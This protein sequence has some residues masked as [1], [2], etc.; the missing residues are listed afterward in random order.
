MSSRR[1]TRTI[2][3]SQTGQWCVGMI[4]V[5]SLC[6]ASTAAMR[7]QDT[8]LTTRLKAA[9]VSKLPQFVEWPAAAL[10]RRPAI[11]VCVAPPDPF[12]AEL[13]TLL[14]GSTV[15]GRPLVARQIATDD[16]L[17]TCQ[18][19]YFP[20]RPGGGHPLLRRAQSLPLLTI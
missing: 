9:I 1:P 16:D 11:E 15:N 14:G 3:R 19:A 12:G 4:A 20:S 8:L 13:A 17:T 5:A 2:A 6:L 10:E 7:A 18:V